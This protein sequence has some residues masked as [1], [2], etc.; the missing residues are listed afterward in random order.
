LSLLG[1]LPEPKPLHDP[2]LAG[3]PFLWGMIC[4]TLT[5]GVWRFVPEG[6]ATDW[7]VLGVSVLI[8]LGFLA[9]LPRRPVDALYLRA[10]GADDATFDARLLIEAALHPELR[11]AGIRAPRRRMP[12]FL[13]PFLFGLFALRYLGARYL[14]LEA[15]SDWFA[16]LWKT[17]GTVRA[18]FIDVRELTAHVISETELA[19]QCVGLER[20]IFVADPEGVDAAI[21]HL[22]EKLGEDRDTLIARTLVWRGR[23]EAEIE[24]FMKD[25]KALENSLPGEP[26]G[27]HWQAFARVR[28]HVMSRRAALTRRLIDVTQWLLGLSMIVAL[29]LMDPESV[30]RALNSAVQSP[31]VRILLGTAS[32]YII[33]PAVLAVASLFRRGAL[34][35]AVRRRSRGV[36]LRSFAGTT[37]TL[38]IFSL[39]LGLALNL[40]LEAAIVKLD[41]SLIQARM[42]AAR[43]GIHSLQNSLELYRL[44]H[45]EYPDKLD[46]IAD[47]VERRQLMDP[48][49]QLY[50]LRIDDGAARVLSR[51]PDGVS[52]SD[53]DVE[54]PPR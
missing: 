17:L 9:A 28:E 20:M 24:R 43:A 52:G 18:V 1:N 8:Q 47:Q 34:E 5:V 54:L 4:L 45:G 44:K 11:L 51:G 42:A 16:R 6:S 15:E 14:S 30:T 21:T 32:G 31:L 27:V 53:D 50:E 40:A 26:A 46:A 12:L 3:R 49:G 22:A 13:R 38:T 25:A 36:L 29:Q 37:R 48:W 33:V 7:V 39:G 41:E 35:R 19:Y 2:L 10:F 23:A